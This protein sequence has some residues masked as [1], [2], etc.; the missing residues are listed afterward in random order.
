MG[1]RSKWC[2]AAWLLL[3]A[4]GCA[5]APQ[6]RYY[7]DVTAVM[8]QE[9]GVYYVDP[10]DSSSVWAKG[11]LQVKVRFMDDHMLD[12]EYDP[13]I[14][15]YTLTGWTD[16]EKGYTPP[17]WTTF[18]V[19]VINRTRERVELDPTQV[20]LR[21]DNG[22]FYYCAQGVGVYKELPHYFNYGYVKW[23]SR[24]GNI[25]YYASYDRRQLW[26]RTIYQREKPV[27]KGRKYTGKLTFPPLPPETRSF[28]L[29]IDNFILAFDRFEP[30]YGN[31]TEFMDL[32][33]QFDVDQGVEEVT[34][35]AGAQESPTG[36]ER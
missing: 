5:P 14:S 19:T 12:E 16:P 35:E 6:L 25:H 30:G 2:W 23:S 8:P 33:F 21:L 10:I 15:P 32:A 20:V 36:G 31:P 27:R 17:Q 34:A 1:M 24:E 11:G 29:E 9:A 28:T 7:I 4:G 13:K 26:N 18:E 3:A 22:N